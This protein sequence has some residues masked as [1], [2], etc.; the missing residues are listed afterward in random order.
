MLLANCISEGSPLSAFEHPSLDGVR[1]LVGAQG[2]G[3]CR[4]SHIA[5]GVVDRCGK[6]E[7]SLPRAQLGHKLIDLP[8]PLV[9]RLERMPWYIGLLRSATGLADKRYMSME[10]YSPLA[11]VMMTKE[12]QSANVRRIDGDTKAA[13]TTRTHRDNNAKSVGN[14]SQAATVATTSRRTWRL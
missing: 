14:L 10:M 12:A 6:I 9:G 4:H 2:G 11:D 13:L 5:N 1:C 3:P 8:V 7:A